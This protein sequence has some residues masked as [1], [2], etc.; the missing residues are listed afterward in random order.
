MKK[1]NKPCHVVQ[2]FN[3]SYEYD[4]LYKDYNSRKD[5]VA[6][7]DQLP[8]QTQ[9]IDNLYVSQQSYQ[10]RQGVLGDFLLLLDHNCC[11]YEDFL[12]LQQLD[13][14]DAE[15]TMTNRINYQAHQLRQQGVLQGTLTRQGAYTNQIGW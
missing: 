1:L 7:K 9:F 6:W 10:Y 3:N 12:N 8:S 14:D 15:D 5:L 2:L 11:T 4:K 13:A